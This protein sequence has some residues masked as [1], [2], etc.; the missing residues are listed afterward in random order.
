M[1]MTDKEL[2]DFLR[3]EV[4]KTIADATR[5]GLSWIIQD[6]H[7]TDLEGMRHIIS[8]VFGSGSESYQLVNDALQHIR[9]TLKGGVL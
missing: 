5:P 1:E 7:K 6:M 4:E 9:T 3:P 8:L 2:T